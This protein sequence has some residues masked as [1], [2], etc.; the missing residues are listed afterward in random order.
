MRRLS[1]SGVRSRISSGRGSD[2]EFRGARAGSDLE[3]REARRPSPLRLEIRDLTPN[4]PREGRTLE[5]R[6]LTPGETIGGRRASYNVWE[7]L[8]RS[9]VIGAHWPRSA[10]RLR[11]KSSPVHGWV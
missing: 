6:D 9:G 2:L 8:S 10:R 4:A 1:P 3:F 5:I 7:N 11:R